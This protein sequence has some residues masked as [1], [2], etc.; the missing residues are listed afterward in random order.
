MYIK[1]LLLVSL[2]TDFNKCDSH[3]FSWAPYDSDEQQLP[4][5]WKEIA[6]LET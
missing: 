6:V 5:Y 2:F 4:R 1:Q 3:V